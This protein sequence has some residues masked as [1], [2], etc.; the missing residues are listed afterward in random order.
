MSNVKST[1]TAERLREVLHYSEETGFFTW[2]I[3]VNSRSP[4]GGVAGTIR[5]KGYIGISVD[6]TIYY[7]HRLAWLYVNNCWPLGQIDHRDGNRKNNQLANLR[8][9][10]PRQNSQNLTRARKGSA[11]GLLGA[12]KHGKS[13]TAHIRVDGHRKHLGSFAT[14][15]LAHA[16]YVKAKREL[17]TGCTI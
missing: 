13:W 11:A 3:R 12:N 7:A 17:H 14:T 8:S 2:R 5:G 16:A 4:I 1:L 15:E 9:V 10:T 6:G